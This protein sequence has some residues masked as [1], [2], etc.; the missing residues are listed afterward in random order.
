MELNLFENIIRF[1]FLPSSYLNESWL[2]LPVLSTSFK[3]VRACFT[4]YQ[5]SDALF[6]LLDIKRDFFGDFSGAFS[7]RRIAF[8]EPAIFDHLA[9]K[10]GLVYINPVFKMSIDGSLIRS[11][12]ASLNENE[13]FFVEKSAEFFG[14]DFLFKT[15]NQ[16]AFSLN[17]SEKIKTQLMRFGYLVFFIL[18]KEE[19]PLFFQRFSL[20]LDSKLVAWMAS[21]NVTLSADQKHQLIQ[22]VIRLLN[23]I[24]PSCKA[25]FVS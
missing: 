21:K 6:S 22:L 19:N 17:E 15:F 11:L 3:K 13:L 20:L 10:L 16:V 23:H 2:E 9:L 12:T 5:S 24:E 1:N 7:Y 14:A 8:L 25:I 18:F 4:P